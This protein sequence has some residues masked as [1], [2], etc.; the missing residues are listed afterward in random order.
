MTA[1]RPLMENCVFVACRPSSHSTR[2][3]RSRLTPSLRPKVLTYQLRDHVTLLES[4]GEIFTGNASH[5]IRTL[6]VRIARGP[7]RLVTVKRPDK[8]ATLCC[9]CFSSSLSLS[10]ISFV[11]S[12]GLSYPSSPLPSD[13]Q[14]L[15]PTQLL[16]GFY[17]QWDNIC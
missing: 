16:A 12:V 14:P 8:S 13:S 17:G 2:G 7:P 6:P 11:P 15:L 9:A 4:S 1:R 10:M 5:G 3:S